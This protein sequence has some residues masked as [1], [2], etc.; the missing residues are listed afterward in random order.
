MKILFICTSNVNRTR[1][2]EE[3]LANTETNVKVLINTITAVFSHNSAYKHYYENTS[4]SL[5]FLAV[6]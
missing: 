4:A 5:K 2:P 1:A 3:L 6:D